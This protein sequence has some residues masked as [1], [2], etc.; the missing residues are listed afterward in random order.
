VSLGGRNAEMTFGIGRI[1]YTNLYGAER[2][3]ANTGGPNHDAKFNLVNLASDGVLAKPQKY[4]AAVT[5]GNANSGDLALGANKSYV[6]RNVVTS[7]GAAVQSEVDIQAS[8]STNDPS[9]YSVGNALGANGVT[10]KDDQGNTKDKASGTAALRTLEEGDHLVAGT[11]GFTVSQAVNTGSSNE[12]SVTFAEVNTGATAFVKGKSYIIHDLKN[13]DGNTD[14]AGSDA[15]FIKAAATNA[16]GSAITGTLRVGQRILIKSDA[17]T[18]AMAGINSLIQNI[19]FT[20][21]TD[22]LTQE[23]EA[24]QAKVNKARVQAGSQ[25]AALESS[26]AYTT[27]LTAQYELGYNTVNDVNFSMETAHLAKNQIL[28]QAATAML[29]QANTGQQSLLQLIQR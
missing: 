26:V 28:Q 20:L 19:E 25:Y 3:I 13:S 17:S 8:A 27:D 21:P 4:G 16:D 10:L 9:S 5:T 18:E 22:I 12:K 11:V 6:I 29:A 14:T 24:V 15:A 23:I 1:A 7:G 2:Q